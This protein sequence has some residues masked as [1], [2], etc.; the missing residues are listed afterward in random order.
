MTFEAF[1]RLLCMPVM[2]A[3]VIAAWFANMVY[4]LFNATFTYPFKLLRG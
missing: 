3:I 2:V 1:L 4:T